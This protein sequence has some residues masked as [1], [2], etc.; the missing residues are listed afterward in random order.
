MNMILPTPTHILLLTY[1]L[2]SCHSGERELQTIFF[3]SFSFLFFFFYLFFPFLFFNT[4]L[5]FFFFVSFLSFSISSRFFSFLLLFSRPAEAPGSVRPTS[6]PPRLVLSPK[7][8]S[9]GD[10]EVESA[11]APSLVVATPPFSPREP[12]VLPDGEYIPRLEL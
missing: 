2:G 12:D 6:P 11:R 5:F 1:I 4:F 10:L 8:K 3:F 7:R 9:V